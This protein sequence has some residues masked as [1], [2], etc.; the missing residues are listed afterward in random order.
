MVYSEQI[1]AKKGIRSMTLIETY[2]RF[3]SGLTLKT[4]LPETVRRATVC[5]CDA[6]D[7]CLVSAPDLRKRGALASVRTDPASGCSLWGTGRFAA[8]EDASFYNGVTGAVSSRNDIS[9]IAGCHPGSILVPVVLALAEENACT[10]EDILC[11]VVAGYE[12]M[13]RM[14]NTLRQAHLPSTFR[15]TAMIGAMGAAIAASRVL[16]LSPEEIASA[17]SF[18]VHSCFGLNEWTWA[19]TGEDVLQNGWAARNGICA[20]RLARAGVPGAKTILEGKAG[21]L[22]AFHAEEKASLLTERLGEHYYIMDVRFKE[23]CACINV[24]TAGQNAA[25]LAGMY[26]PEIPEIERVDV[27]CSEHSKSFPG[28]DNAD[29]R[30]LVQAIMSIQFTVAAS[31][32]G[33]NPG[34]IRWSAPY[35]PEILALASKCRLIAD[36]VLSESHYQRQGSK[37]QVTMKDGTAYSREQEDV[38]TPNEETV[39]CRFERNMNERTDPNTAERICEGF[40]SVSRQMQPAGL[41]RLLAGVSAEI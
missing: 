37:I 13:I 23:I 18:A 11:A 2:G 7:C 20:M 16:R 5:I 32:I 25:A 38:E 36:P 17:A 34:G 9:R 10:G 12:T 31:M 41:I 3:A 21:F 4:L 14:G 19:G 6:I 40:E 22:Q 33:Q 28:C 30:N 26:H 39:L 24:Q 1:N 27:W 29:V 35:D 15:G 8:A